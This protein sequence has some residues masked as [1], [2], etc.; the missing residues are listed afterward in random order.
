MRLVF[1]GFLPGVIS[2]L[3][4]SKVHQ[5]YPMITKDI[6]SFNL[7]PVGTLKSVFETTGRWAAAGLFAALGGM[8][9]RYGEAQGH[10]QLWSTTQAVF[11]AMGGG[12]QKC[13]KIALICIDGLLNLYINTGVKILA[14][15]YLH[16]LGEMLKKAEGLYNDFS[17]TLARWWDIRTLSECL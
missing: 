7:L 12:W 1:Q 3:N 13:Q 9:T 8:C 4:Y 11:H 15:N 16:Q 5:S 6:C 2:P 10:W 17:L 14:S